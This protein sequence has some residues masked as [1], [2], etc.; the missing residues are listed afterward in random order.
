MSLEQRHEFLASKTEQKYQN[1]LDVTNSNI[2]ELISKLEAHKDSMTSEQR[3]RFHGAMQSSTDKTT[4]LQESKERVS[5]CCII[6]HHV[7]NTCT[8]QENDDPDQTRCG[9][10]EQ[11]ATDRIEPEVFEDLWE[12]VFVHHFGRQ[13]AVEGGLDKTGDECD[14]SKAAQSCNVRD[15]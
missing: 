2:N 4:D 9:R 13:M 10:P 6:V 1:Q 3:K 5:S 14:K 7:W 15:A 11:R 12:V 8:D